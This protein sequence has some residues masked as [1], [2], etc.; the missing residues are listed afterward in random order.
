VEECID[1][2]AEPLFCIFLP[3]HPT[4]FGDF[5]NY[6]E[7]E[8]SL[9]VAIVS[10]G[11]DSVTLA[12]LLQEQQHHLHLLSFDYGQ[13]HRKELDYACQCAERIQAPHHVVDL[14]N[15]SVLLGGSSLTDSQIDVPDGHYAEETMKITVV[16]NRNAIMLSIAAGYA[17]SIQAQGVAAAIHAGDHYIYP[18]CRPEFAQS[19]EQMTKLATEG[20]SDPSFRFLTPFIDKPKAEIVSIGAKLGVPYEETWSCYKGLEFHCGTCGTCVERKEA[21]SLA[22]VNDPTKYLVS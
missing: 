7:F 14:K 8:M 9:I 3:Q 20:F 22:G 4:E 15:L 6:Q 16:P 21:I 13:R 17:V 19:F 10:G 12:Y 5:Q 2:S 18:D 11:M 1:F